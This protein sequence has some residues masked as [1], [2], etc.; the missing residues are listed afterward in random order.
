MHLG[1]RGKAT[2]MVVSSVMAMVGVAILM[3]LKCDNLKMA[4]VKDKQTGLLVYTKYHSLYQL[5][6]E[7]L[8]L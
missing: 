2:L 1:L 5:C 6:C 8:I 3:F 4:G 7:P